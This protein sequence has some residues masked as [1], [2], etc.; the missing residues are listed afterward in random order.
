MIY[1]DNNAT[2]IMPPEARRAMLEW[3]NRGNPSASYTSAQEARAMMDDFRKFIAQVHQFD[4]AKYQ[5]VFTSGASES[6][7][8]FIHGVIATAQQRLDS[9]RLGATLPH[10]IISAIEHKSLL[11]AVRN[12]EARGVITANYIAPTKSGHIR[13]EDIAAAT[14]PSTCAVIV[15][16]ANNETGAINDIAAIGRAAHRAKAYFHCDTVQTFGK[17]PIAPDAN[18][19]DSFSVSFHKMGG[20]PGVG[21]LIIRRDIDI[22]PLIFGTQNEGSRGG[23][24]NLP[25]IGASFAALKISSKN[26]RAKN[27]KMNELKALI[28]KRLAAR[29]PTRYYTEVV[30]GSG[31]GGGGGALVSPPLEIVFLSRASEY[32]L[33]N[34]LLLSIV[35]RTPPLICNG[36]LKDAMIKRGFIISVGSACNTAST[37]ASHVLFALGADE[38]IRKGALRI[39]LGDSNTQEEVERFAAVLIEEITRVVKK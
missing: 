1:L 23:T 3:T 39:T 22:A 6:N 11:E 34:T 30:A 20:P 33:S 9:T 28:M 29:W 31:G 10:I 26:R 2:T 18:E 25:G 4:L 37:R 5:I 7:A 13:P 21:V 15:M 8:T 38:A 35:V 14:L 32:Y 24:E 19:V 12:Y 36:Q 16:H 27:A 17:F